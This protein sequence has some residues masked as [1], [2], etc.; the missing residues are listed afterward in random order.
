MSLNPEVTKRSALS[1]QVCVPADYSDI[2]VKEFA[3]LANPAGLPAGWLVRKQGDPALCGCD[4]RVPCKSRP[5]FVH[6][7][8]DC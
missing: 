2:R 7:M 4:E 8:L 5:D 6:V 1:C 3:D